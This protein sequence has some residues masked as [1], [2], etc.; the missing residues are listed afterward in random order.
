MDQPPRCQKIRPSPQS[1]AS[2]G[3]DTAPQSNPGTRIAVFSSPAARHAPPLFPRRAVTPH[4][5]D[6]TAWPLLRPLRR[7]QNRHH[8]HGALLSKG[9]RPVHRVRLVTGSKSTHTRARPTHERAAHPTPPCL[10][11]RHTHT[12]TRFVPHV[13]AA[14]PLSS[15]CPH[16]SPARPPPERRKPRRWLETAL[17]SS[18][19]STCHRATGRQQQQRTSA[20]RPRTAAAR[21]GAW[22]PRTRG[23]RRSTDQAGNIARAV[24]AREGARMFDSPAL[25]PPREHTLPPRLLPRA[26]PLKD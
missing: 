7:C 14:P 26:A 13:P 19:T 8:V 22:R 12:H 10:L 15:T 5:K 3:Q 24:W 6:I 20:P 16:G 18:R 9:L 4:N 2:S 1:R 17:P 25:P 21:E 23:K 11:T